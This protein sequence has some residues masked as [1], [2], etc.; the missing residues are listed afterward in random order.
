MCEGNTNVSDRCTT[1]A[2]SVFL[3]KGMRHQTCL[4]FVLFHDKPKPGAGLQINQQNLNL[5][6]I[7]YKL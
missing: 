5:L 1:S 6:L 3:K 7:N 2:Q 4:L